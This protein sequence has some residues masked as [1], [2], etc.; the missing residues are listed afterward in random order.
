MC[1]SRS[2][3]QSASLLG[4][5]GPIFMQCISTVGDAA[6]PPA[7]SQGAPQA[8][9]PRGVA[10]RD[11]LGRRPK[12]N[13]KQFLTRASHPERQN[14]GQRPSPAWCDLLQLRKPHRASVTHSV[15][16][17]TIVPL[18]TTGDTLVLHTL[19]HH[20][21]KGRLTSTHTVH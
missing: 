17:V 12:S 9:R 15:H 10:A 21:T 20:G 14:H 16:W 5:P 18:C 2:A 4:S 8:A 7:L 11:D 3:A 13:H 1:R 19:P 6:S